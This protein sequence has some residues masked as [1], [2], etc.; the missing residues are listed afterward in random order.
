[1]VCCPG[2]LLAAIS[3]LMEEFRT[4]TRFEDGRVLS[5]R[6]DVKFHSSSVAALFIDDGRLL[7][8]D[9]GGS[10]SRSEEG[11]AVVL[12]APDGCCWKGDE[13]REP[14]D[15]KDANGSAGGGVAVCCGRVGAGVEDCE[16]GWEPLREE[17]IS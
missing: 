1:M 10:M 12:W 3:I 14:V 5:G 4:C 17:K 11:D 7:G 6:D 9:N 15:T 2:T 13:V 8:R 16:P